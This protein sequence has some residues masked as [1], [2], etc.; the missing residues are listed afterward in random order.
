[1]T[2]LTELLKQRAPHVQVVRG[3]IANTI[4]DPSQD[5]Y[6]TVEAFDGR[7]QRWGP[8]MWTPGSV[9]PERG[10]DC[11]VL[12]DEREAPWV[13]CPDEV[14]ADVD[15]TASATTKPPGSQASVVVTEPDPNDFHFDFGIPRGDTGA[16]GPQGPAGAQGP[17]GPQG[18]QG[19]Q[20]PQGPAGSGIP[21]NA[22]VDLPLAN[23]WQHY[24]APFTRCQ[25]R[26]DS[27][28][29]HT[30]LRGLANHPTNANQ[31]ICV[32]PNVPSYAHIFECLTSFGATGQD[33]HRVDI[34][35]NGYLG[36]SGWNP[37]GAGWISLDGIRYFTD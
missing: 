22:W 29:N 12:L 16:T 2:A 8:C 18:I 35:I 28:N 11:V 13:L 14:L 20:G 15:I 31:Y 32:L 1:M 17:Q 26:R 21:M 19:P 9:E 24:G 7:R 23:G 34:Q 37:V 4:T 25:Y 33:S 5:L 10:D 6:V 36:P 27:A 3:T 30:Y